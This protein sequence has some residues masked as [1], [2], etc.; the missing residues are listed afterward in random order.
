MNLQAALTYSKEKYLSLEKEGNQIIGVYYS[1][2]NNSEHFE[3]FTISYNAECSIEDSEDW[4]DVAYNG[5]TEWGGVNF[6]E[7]TK[8][9]PEPCKNL[10]YEVFKAESFMMLETWYILKIIFPELPD[11]GSSEFISESEFEARASKLVNKL[12]SK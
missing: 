4:F 2:N 11:Q 9:I 1:P 5:E 10:N 7:L 8:T 12:N 6:D 3:I